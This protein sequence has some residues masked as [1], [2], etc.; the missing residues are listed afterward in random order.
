MAIEFKT[1][2]A[3][4]RKIS[5]INPNLD[6]RISIIGSIIDLEENM[7]VVDDGT[8]KIDVSF[9]EETPQPELKTGQLIRIFGFVIPSEQVE[10]QAEVIQDLSELKTEYLDIIRN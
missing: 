7:A 9:S 6:S 3:V 5:D 1:E 10:L 8:G 2:P 4:K